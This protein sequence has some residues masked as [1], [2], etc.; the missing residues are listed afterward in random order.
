MKRTVLAFIAAI[1]ILVAQVGNAIPP[2]KMSYGPF[3]S[4]GVPVADCND[5]Q[6]LADWTN[7]GFYTLF[8]DSDGIPIRI[9]FHVHRAEI[10]YY[11][12]LDPSKYLTG[13]PYAPQNER[14][15]FVDGTRLGAI[16]GL[17]FKV[18]I[19]GEG[20]IF[21][22]VGR[23]IYDWNTGDVIVQSGP[24]DFFDGNGEGLCAALAD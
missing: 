16:H 18:V 22:D 21:A 2:M 19:P 6:V 15:Y 5:F 24:H 23:V 10:I 3:D 1:L 7:E 4:V 13:M 12:S 14:Q 8:F 20:T 11:N 17:L 9:N